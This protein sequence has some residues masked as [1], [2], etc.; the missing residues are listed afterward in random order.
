[1][2]AEAAYALTRPMC[3][4]VSN[5]PHAMS[6][7]DVRGAF[8]SV[9]GGTYRCELVGGVA[10]V[11]FYSAAD[12]W[13]AVDRFNGGGLNGQSIAVTLMPGRSEAVESWRGAAG[14]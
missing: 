3:V 13:K 9:V 7:R 14:A 1:M 10:W 6:A 4:E 12:A 8:E 5:V 2:R 11:Y